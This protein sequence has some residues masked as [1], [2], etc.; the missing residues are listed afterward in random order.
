[1]RVSLQDFGPRTGVPS[2]TVY[3]ED[4]DRDARRPAQF[5]RENEA[6]WENRDFDE[7]G[8]PNG[9]DADRGDDGVHNND[10]RYPGDPPLD[11]PPALYGLRVA[12]G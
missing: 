8:I 11:E 5:A 3:D 4:S 9:I 6:A 2:S 12:R 7:D 10:D 1:M